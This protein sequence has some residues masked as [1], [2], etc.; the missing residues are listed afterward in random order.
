MNCLY[1]RPP[2]PVEFQKTTLP[3]SGSRY[4]LKVSFGSVALNG[5]SIRSHGQPVASVEY[6][7]VKHLETGTQL[8]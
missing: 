5:F 6:A 7:E 4:T 2:G 8:I 1:C 3:R